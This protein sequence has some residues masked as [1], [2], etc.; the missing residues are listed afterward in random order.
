MSGALAVLFG[1]VLLTDPAGVGGDSAGA[2]VAAA[3]GRVEDRVGREKEQATSAKVTSRSSDFDLQA[4][5]VMFEG[6]VVVRYSGSL[7]MCADRLYMFVSGSNELNRVVALGNVSI[8][9]ELRSGSCERAVYRRRRGEIEMFG[10]GAGRKAVLTE[11]GD[12]ERGVEG[13]RIRL[14]LDSG[15]VEV[16]DSAIVSEKKGREQLL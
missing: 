6:D 11:R 1:V 7:T 3:G 8:S 10:D 15:Q 14:W 5:V 4:G 13:S 16:R 9:D 12:G 2:G